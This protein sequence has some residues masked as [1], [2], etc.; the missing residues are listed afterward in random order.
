MAWTEEQQKA[1]DLEGKNILVSAGAGSGKTAV[2]TARVL[3]KLQEGVSIQDLLILTF[4]NAAAQEM[5]ERIRNG[6]RKD[7]LLEEQLKYID[8]ASIMTFDAYSLSLVKKYHTRLNITKSIEVTNEV[9]VSLEKEKILD[10]IFDEYY[11]KPSPSFTKFIQDFC[12]KDDN[13]LKAS[14]LSMYKKIELKFDKKEYLENYLSIYNTDKIHSFVQEYISF[15]FQKRDEIKDLFISLNDYFDGDFVSKMEDNFKGLLNARSYLELREGLSSYESIRVPSNSLEEG[16]KIKATIFQLVKELE[17]YSSYSSEEEM[18]DEL[19]STN[20]NIEVIVS[21]LQELDKRLDS[22]KR[23]HEVFTFTDISRLAIQVV[24]E[25]PDIQKELQEKYQEIMVDEYQD[26]SDTQEAFISLIAHN[27]VYMV[28]DIKQSIYRFR[29]AN[30]YLFKEKYDSYQNN[31]GGEKIDL[32]KNFRSREEV[33]DDINL[34]FLH[35]MDNTYGGADYKASHQMVFGNK[36]YQEEGYTKE[37]HHMEILTYEKEKLGRLSLAEEEAFL[38]AE[39]IKNKMENHYPVFDKDL[40]ILR[41]IEYKDFVILLDRG[42]DFNLYKKIFETYQIPLTVLQDESLKQED[43]VL[44]IKSLLKFLICLKKK[45]YENDFKYSYVSLCRSFLYPVEDSIIYESV[46][47]N[48]ILESDLVQ[49][50]M[51]LLEEMDS[52]S[53]SQFFLKVLDTFHYEEK[54]ITIGNIA[55]YEARLE[56]IYR[57]CQSFEKMGHTIY[58]FV[59]YLEDVFDKDLD[60]S[61]NISLEDSNSCRIMTIHKSKGLEFPICYFPGVSV[62]FNM[63]DVKDRIIYDNQYGIILPKVEESYKDTILKILLKNKIKQEEISEKIRLFYVAVTRAKEKMIFVIPK[64][65][66]EEMY[67]LVPNYVRDMYHSFLS[68]LKS[69]YSYLLPYIKDVNIIGNKDYLKGVEGEILKGDSKEKIEVNEISIPTTMVEEKHYSK[70]KDT[71]TKEEIDLMK[72]GSKI[73]EVLEEIDFQNYDLSLYDLD[74]FSKNKILS[75]LKSYFMKD[76]LNYS[77]Y[78]EYEFIKDDTVGVIDL[79][80]EGDN[81]Y[82]I[83]DYKLK[84]IDDESYDKQLNGYKEFVQEKTH[85]KV[86]CFLYSLLDEV[87]REVV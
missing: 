50:C 36:M 63:S 22:Y 72:I 25:N 80:I 4:T 24:K 65:E 3:R 60:L 78:K 85:K 10:E 73:H 33:L 7:P 66:E 74:S 23:E 32:L 19:L 28:G 83:I 86:S 87:Y 47:Q 16:K 2:L 21:I 56:Y 35:V 9:M 52:L 67:E 5:R 43:D 34:L 68:I 62:G 44:C 42:R 17:K 41:D 1:I 53:F 6:I 40:G 59:S 49:L 12:L 54:I 69:I 39:D 30:P 79:L 84:N 20:S 58:E 76:K 64:Q 57:L 29:N 55:Y 70:R 45:E 61:F 15:L 75:F 71:Y 82:F 48:K 26:T 77:M 11:L 8:S 14:L 31:N 13:G 27:N 51:P 81:E 38:I 18:M 37:N 46:S